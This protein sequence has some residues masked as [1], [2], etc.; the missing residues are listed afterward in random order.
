MIIARVA[1]IAIPPPRGTSLSAKR[2][3]LASETKPAFKAHLFTTA[4]SIAESKNEPATNP[5]D[6]AIMVSILT[7]PVISFLLY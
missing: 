1:N 7:A 4:V 5:A 6:I 3:A 2:S